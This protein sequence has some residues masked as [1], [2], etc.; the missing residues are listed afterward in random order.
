MVLLETK[1][2][3]PCPPRIRDLHNV[4]FSHSFGTPSLFWL[5]R[6][7]CLS[8][9]FGRF[10]FCRVFRTECHKG[11]IEPLTVTRRSQQNAE[12]EHSAARFLM[13][14]S[15]APVGEYFPESKRAHSFTGAPEAPGI[16]RRIQVSAPQTSRFAASQNG[17]NGRG[18]RDVQGPARPPVHGAELEPCLWRGKS[19]CRWKWRGKRA[20]PFIGASPAV[21]FHHLLI[22]LHTWV[23]RRARVAEL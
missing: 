23:R 15:A 11:Y 16:I 13:L 1:A 4:G 7:K 6:V 21:C 5:Q 20:F 19:D 18:R 12:G 8:W 2:S 22:G 17:K 9:M 14:L 10:Y 3:Q